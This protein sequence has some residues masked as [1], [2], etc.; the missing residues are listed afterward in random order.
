MSYGNGRLELPHTSWALLAAAVCFAT[1]TA[2]GDNSHEDLESAFDLI[3][4]RWERI[5]PFEAEIRAFPMASHPPKSV[6][7]D[8]WNRQEWEL[9]PGRESYARDI[10]ARFFEDGF[11]LAYT[12][13][14][15]PS[16]DE[17]LS[18]IGGEFVHFLNTNPDRPTAFIKNSATAARFNWDM[19][20][21][22]FEQAF[23]D[24]HENW[25]ALIDRFGVRCT[26]IED[27]DGVRCW[28]LENTRETGSRRLTIWA[29]VD[30]DGAPFRAHDASIVDEHV[31]GESEM[32]II[33]YIPV[34]DSFVPATALISVT[35][36]NVD[37]FQMSAYDIVDLRIGDA[38]KPVSIRNTL[39]SGTEVTDL[40]AGE[41]W[42]L[43]SNRGK[44]N[45]RPVDRQ[46]RKAAQRALQAQI[47]QPGLKRSRTAAIVGI[48]VA[49]LAIAAAV[50]FIRRRV[51]RI[52]P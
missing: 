35:N 15:A 51:V 48:A 45:I 5:P 49:A 18:F 31:V 50:V 11:S 17:S 10:T 23:F 46:Q 41:H 24:E 30:H 14:D 52:E 8:R 28:R 12:P 37:C 21:T 47:D 6:D 9:T 27:V 36:E 42:T 29:S 44:A 39:P 7:N 4:S 20:L 33:D 2:S 38:Y 32:R 25:A 19:I 26:A 1:A 3:V 40:V 13:H 43:T 22:V 16:S 34:G